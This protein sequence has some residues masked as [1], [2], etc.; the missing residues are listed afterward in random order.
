VP[1][2]YRVVAKHLAQELKK[3]PGDFRDDK[4]LTTQIAE[5]HAAIM[6]LRAV[7]SSD[8]EITYIATQG[9]VACVEFFARVERINALPKPQSAGSL[10]VE[11]FIHGLYG[12]ILAGYSLGADADAKQKA[13]MTE[14][15]ALAAAMEKADAVHLLLPKIAR[16]YSVPVSAGS[17]RIRVD[18]DESWYGFGPHDWCCL[19]NA[20]ARLMDCTVVVELTGANGEI[21]KNVH[22]INDWPPNSW[23]Y[24][25]YSAGTVVSGR[26]VG[27]MTVFNVST[28]GVTLLSP[29]F[30]TKVSYTY[31][32][33]EKDKDIAKHCK[34][35][36]LSWRYQPFV[37]GIIWDTQRGVK[38][39]LTDCPRFGKC[40]IDLSFKRGK[41]SKQWYWSIDSWKPGE[42]KTFN[43]PTGGLS[44]DPTTIEAVLSF[45][46]TAY[47][48]R[49]NLV[50]K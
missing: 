29:R 30:S 33:Q 48:K 6:D 1:E 21:R 10:F 42:E 37:K 19:Y 15:H 18:F 3:N 25:R 38:V 27:R 2:E 40:R 7:D 36:K 4:S 14:M 5:G 41:D 17:G 34:D 24:A 22:Y 28:V 50:K 16:K 49:W 31:I 12:N 32:G 45:P 8:P 43:P 47:K 35:V 20:G 39:T 44:Y 9:E 13:I 23:R 11:S 26:Y 46:G